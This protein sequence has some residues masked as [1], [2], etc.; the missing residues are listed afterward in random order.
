M[1]KIG[2]TVTTLDGD[3][4]YTPQTG[5]EQSD[6]SFVLASDSVTAVGFSGFEEIGGGN[7]NFWNFDIPTADP[8]DPEYDPAFPFGRKQVKVKINGVIQPAYGNITVYADND[9][10]ASTSYSIGRVDRFGDT[11][12]NWLTYDPSGWVGSSYD[13]ENAPDSTNVVPYKAW[14]ENK[15]GKLDGSNTA[16]KR[17]TGANEYQYTPIMA[18]DSTE[19]IVGIPAYDNSLVWKKWVQDNFSTLSGNTF[20]I[21]G[22]RI[23][24]DSKASSNVTGKIYQTIQGAISYASTQTPSATSKWEIFI[25][26]HHSTGYAEDITLIRFVELF[27]LGKVLITGKLATTHGVSQTW[28]GYDARLENIFFNTVNKD[29]N[30]KNLKSFDC[31]FKTNGSGGE[32]NLIIDGAQMQNSGI[33]LQN[34]VNVEIYNSVKVNRIQNCFGN[35]NL[36]WL[37]TDKVYSFNYLTGDQWEF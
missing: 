25:M 10:P 33:Y 31:I 9:E 5:L 18:L 21:N 1:Q 16:D 13:P 6:F 29:I 12:F 26:P 30:L 32:V 17:W 22:N 24:V 34:D 28:T 7:Y 36:V 23:I 4:N 11:M 19:Y 37:S 35:A 20:P 27:G 3:E 8:A 2:L 15:F 14:I